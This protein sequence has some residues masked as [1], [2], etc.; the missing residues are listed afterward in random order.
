MNTYIYISVCVCARARVRV[1]LPQL[2]TNTIN[3]L[4]DFNRV[5]FRI[6]LLL[7]LDA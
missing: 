5:E 4:V 6:F 1:C 3:Y 2:P 7:T